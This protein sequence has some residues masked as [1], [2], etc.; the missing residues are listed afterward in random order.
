ML[1]AMLHAQDVSDFLVD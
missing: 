1:L